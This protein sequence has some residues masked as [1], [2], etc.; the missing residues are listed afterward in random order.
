[1]LLAQALE[2]LFHRLDSK[3]RCTPTKTVLWCRNTTTEQ[4]HKETI[5]QGWEHYLRVYTALAQFS[6]DGHGTGV[7]RGQLHAGVC[8][9]HRQALR[10]GDLASRNQVA[11]Q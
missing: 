10:R 1:M 3:L 7:Q 2:R 6:Q 4:I 9:K 11:H 8:E 5:I